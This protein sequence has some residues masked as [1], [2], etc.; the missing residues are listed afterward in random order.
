MSKHGLSHKSRA[1]AS[2]PLTRELQQLP[3][4]REVR[5]HGRMSRTETR[6]AGR[7]SQN[8]KLAFLILLQGSYLQNKTCFTKYQ[9]CGP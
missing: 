1:R 6:E 5:T 7:E 9:C 4:E 3:R 2:F 8:W